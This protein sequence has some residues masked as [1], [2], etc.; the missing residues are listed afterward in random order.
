MTIVAGFSGNVSV[1]DSRVGQLP[2]D[3][4]ILIVT[5]SY[6]G[7]P[8]DNAASFVSWI[9]NLPQ[10]ANS[11]A[12]D[13]V[14]FAVFGCG[15]R[16]WARTYQRVPTL[17]DTLLHTHGASRLMA[18]GEADAASLSMFESFEEFSRRMWSNFAEVCSL[19]LN[20]A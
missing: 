5:S 4:P 19:S 2:K 9:Q 17:I 16:E 18:R 3:G 8:P 13:G 6:E 7:E 14:R 1:L 15:N 20:W 11:C 12:L 10:S